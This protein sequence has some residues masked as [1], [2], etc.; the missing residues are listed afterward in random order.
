MP[1]KQRCCFKQQVGGIVCCLLGWIWKLTCKHFQSSLELQI[2]DNEI[3]KLKIMEPKKHFMYY[4]AIEITNRNSPTIYFNFFP[5][6]TLFRRK[7]HY[8]YNGIW[9]KKS[10]FIFI[11]V[12][13]LWIWSVFSNDYDPIPGFE[14]DFQKWFEKN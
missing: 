14:L 2:E 8:I 1:L 13:M 4:W 5:Q 3:H 9:I 10:I 7:T 11:L 12:R 6:I